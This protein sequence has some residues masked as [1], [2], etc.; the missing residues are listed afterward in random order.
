MGN[1][2]SSRSNGWAWGRLGAWRTILAA[3]FCTRCRITILSSSTL[4]ALLKQLKMAWTSDKISTN[5]KQHE[6][7]QWLVPLHQ[8]YARRQDTTQILVTIV[9]VSAD[10][11]ALATPRLRDF[12]CHHKFPVKPDAE[13]KNVTVA[14]FLH[15][16][17]AKFHLWLFVSNVLLFWLP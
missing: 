7:V 13:S 4:L 9:R 8:K 2:C 15:R 5:L 17:M 11:A 10:A 3:L 6:L 14:F 1:Q 12:C 16:N